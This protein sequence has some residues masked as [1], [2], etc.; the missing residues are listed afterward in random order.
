MIC[1]LDKSKISSLWL[2]SVAEHVNLNLTLSQ[3]SEDRFSHDVAHIYAFSGDV[4]KTQVTRTWEFNS[5]FPLRSIVIP[6]LVFSPLFYLI[7]FLSEAGIVTMSGWSIFCSTRLIMTVLSLWI[8]ICVYRVLKFIKGDYSKGVLLVA[9]SYVTLTY[10]CH[11]FTNSFETL[12]FS[13]L[14]YVIFTSS[15]SAES[16]HSRKKSKI[17]VTKTERVAERQVPEKPVVP[18]FSCV[19][20]GIISVA[21]IF[22]R[23]T[24]VIFSFLPT[25]WWFYMLIKYSECTRHFV[26]QT[27][28]ITLSAAV[29]CS[30]FCAI[31]SLYFNNIPISDIISQVNYC[32]PLSSNT[33]ECLKTVFSTYFVFTPWNFVQ[34]NTK[35]ENLAEHGSHPFYLH[36]CVNMPLL[37]GPLVYYLLKSMGACIKAL[38][39]AS[40]NNQSDNHSHVSVIQSLTAFIL[41]PILIFSIFPHQEPRFLIPLLPFMILLASISTESFSKNFIA[42][43]ITLNVILTIIF[44]VMHQ[45]GLIP[46]ILKLQTLYT[47]DKITEDSSVSYNFIFS[48]TYMPPQFPLLIKS[49][50]VKI[51]DLKGGNFDK[52]LNVIQ[53]I[54]ESIGNHDNIETRI[55]LITP[56]IIY[57]DLKRN[58]LN[59]SLV[60]KFYPHLSFEDPPRII[61]SKNFSI[62]SRF[63]QIYYQLFLLL[64][65]VH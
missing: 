2:A 50:K 27:F 29:T 4:L 47:T 3:T 21:G 63:K 31:D 28:L 58:N 53:N 57:D 64:L 46:C 26:I 49:S 65:E 41:F 56:G 51:W 22:N 24:F 18:Y 38:I 34:Y 33:L 19:A 36:F 45:G 17:V 35:G 15:N 55:F 40:R 48:G 1:I 14:I 23:P 6:K 11:T 42:S 32:L 25:L 52:V 5:T 37:F 13:S 16:K 7:K 54:K 44:G 43:F 10:Q 8:D 60:D 20:F 12:L 9:S 39:K 61:V 59:I 62:Y 30:F